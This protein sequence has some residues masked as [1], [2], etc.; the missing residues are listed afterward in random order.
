MFYRLSVVLDN[1]GISIPIY[2][3]LSIVDLALTRYSMIY[4]GALEANPV[5]DF[6]FAQSFYSAAAFKL[7]IVLMV[8]LICNHLWQHRQVRI[9]LAA[10]NIIML[11]VVTYELANILGSIGA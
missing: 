2:A 5:M 11:A 7:G 8:G 1:F 6:L 9:V 10:G 3:F 4:L